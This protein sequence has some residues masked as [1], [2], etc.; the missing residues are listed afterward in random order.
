MERFTIKGN[1][2]FIKIGIKEVF[3]FPNK[4]S[5]TGGYDCMAD[6]EINI[7]GYR[8]T[9][10][11]YTSTGEL[12]E[13]FSSLKQG[14]ENLNGIAEY[15]TLEGNLNINVTYNELGQVRILG[16]FQ[17]SMHIETLLKFEISSDQSYI[18]YTLDELEILVKKYGDLKGK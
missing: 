8:A 12:F 13:F 9:G 10:D 1:D 11:F 16:F 17:Q 2:G 6:I 18:K 15:L 3:G 4:T 5:H 7:P 14:Q